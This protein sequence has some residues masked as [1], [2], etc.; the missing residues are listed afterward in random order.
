MNFL[1]N[2]LVKHDDRIKLP[3]SVPGIFLQKNK[4]ILDIIGPCR[5]FVHIIR[6]GGYERMRRV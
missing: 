5:Y 1:R 6:D 4:I 2:L 3:K